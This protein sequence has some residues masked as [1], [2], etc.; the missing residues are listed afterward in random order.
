MQMISL[1]DSLLK[2]V[3]L[4]LRCTTAV[5]LLLLGVPESCCVPLSDVYWRTTWIAETGRIVPS[6]PR[7]GVFRAAVLACSPQGH[8][9]PQSHLSVFI[10]TRTTE[11]VNEQG[12]AARWQSNPTSQNRFPPA[13]HRAASWFDFRLHLMLLFPRL[14]PYGIL[15]TGPRTGLVEFVS[16]SQPVS[17]VLS[18]HNGSILE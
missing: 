18:A 12:C 15:A 4:D 5:T 6:R 9:P 17:A 1:M 16:G 10:E 7:A 14:K 13:L 8:P 3:N 11:S 2:R